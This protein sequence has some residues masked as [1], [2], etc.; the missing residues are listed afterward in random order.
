ME[1]ATHSRQ[2]DRNRT[3]GLTFHFRTYVALLG[4]L[5]FA[6]VYMSVG[7]RWH[8]YR[9]QAGIYAQQELESTFKAAEYLRAAR[10]PG[11]TADAPIRAKE[12]RRLADMHSKVAEEATRLREFYERSW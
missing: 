9:A 7:M 5:A 10:N 3:P 12:Y 8:F 2:S 6:L 11:F 4:F 1:Y